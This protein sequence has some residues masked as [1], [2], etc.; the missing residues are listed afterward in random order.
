MVLWCL[1][2]GCHGLLQSTS[3]SCLDRP[4]N[5]TK[6]ISEDNGIIKTSIKYHSYSSM[7]IQ[8]HWVR[9]VRCVQNFDKEKS[10]KRASY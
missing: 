5:A 3:Y 4:R 1:Q 7:L 6:N 10:W 2:G 8:I 9:K